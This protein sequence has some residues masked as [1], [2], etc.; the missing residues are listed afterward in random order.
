MSVNGSAA[1]IRLAVDVLDGNLRSFCFLFNVVPPVTSSFSSI[2]RLASYWYRLTR[3]AD[4]AT[5]INDKVWSCRNRSDMYKE[6]RRWMTTAPHTIE[7]CTAEVWIWRILKN[8]P[9]GEGSGAV[10][11]GCRDVGVVSDVLWMVWGAQ[12]RETGGHCQFFHFNHKIL[13][14][15]M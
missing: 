13:Y 6:S 15:K 4:I 7:T 5:R 12:W 2:L 10:F 1:L 3:D 14:S 9:M 8:R 11:L